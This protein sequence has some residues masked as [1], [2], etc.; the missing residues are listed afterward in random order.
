M[1]RAALATVA[2]ASWAC[3]A[4][5]GVAP[6]ATPVT[7]ESADRRDPPVERGQATY[8]ADSLAGHRT[9]SGEPY[10]PRALTAAHRR[11]PFGAIVE[12]ARPDGR[13]TVVRINDR[14]PFGDERRVVDLSRRAAEELGILGVGVAEVTLRVV[15]MPDERP[16]RTRR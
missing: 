12:V 1:I 3:A 7:P 15:S 11:L 4:S 2:L 16:R 10:D 5:G 9:A 6:D 8:Y 14:G 13:S